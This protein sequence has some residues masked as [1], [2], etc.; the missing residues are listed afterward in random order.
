MRRTPVV[1]AAALL[2]AAPALLR[3]QTV[4]GR[5][6]DSVTHRPLARVLVHLVPGPDTARDTVYAAGETAADGVFALMAPA[7]GT[8][9]VRLAGFY[10][11]PPLTLATADTT[12]EHEYPIG[13]MRA[14][15][16]VNIHYVLR[17]AELDS[18]LRS[19]WPLLEFQVEKQA[20]MVPGTLQPRYPATTRERHGR[21]VVQFVV[22]TTGRAELSTFKVLVSSNPA[23]SASVRTALASAR[24]YPAE[25]GGRRVRQLV[26][27]PANFELNGPDFPAS[28]LFGPPFK[29]IPPATGDP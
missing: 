14:P 1:H 8:Y 22:D 28:P 18:V 9:R 21:V 19:G 12:D 11:G 29:P 23:F 3:G 25:L 17:G 7:P 15:Q 20:A 24:F 13:S 10:L 16:R 4:T 27:L 26:Q 5:V 6:V 2:A